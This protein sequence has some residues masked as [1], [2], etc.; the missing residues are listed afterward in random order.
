MHTCLGWCSTVERLAIKC[1]VLSS[2]P[3]LE[4][5]KENKEVYRYVVIRGKEQCTSQVE[6]HLW[7][8]R[9]LSLERLPENILVRHNIITRDL[10]KEVLHVKESQT[11]EIWGVLNPVLSLKIKKKK[12]HKSRGW[13]DSPQAWKSQGSDYLPESL[14]SIVH[15]YF[16]LVGGINCRTV[17]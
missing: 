5:N 12:I 13:C 17:G 11:K 2:I 6:T 8:I 4:N 1:K 16:S 10:Q 9:W 7:I 15:L 3:T 14:D